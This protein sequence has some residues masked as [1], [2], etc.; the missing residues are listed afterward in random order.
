[1]IIVERDGQWFCVHQPDHARLG[2]QLAAHWIKPAAMYDGVWRRFVE[3]VGAHDDGWL[4]AE[5]QPALDAHGQPFDFITLPTHQHIEIWRRSIDL[6]AQRDI[7]QALLVA[8][9]ARW[10]YT[11]YSNHPGPSE[12]AA[13]A[14]FIGELTQRIVEYLQLLRRGSREDRD[15]VEPARMATAAA[16]L[17]FFDSLS[18]LL[19]GALPAGQRMRS[20]VFDG[21]QAT[22]DTRWADGN[23]ALL[24]C[25]PWPFTTD[26]VHVRC[27]VRAIPRR[28]C[29]DGAELA[30][31]LAA[32]EPQDKTWQIRP[33]P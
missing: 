16:L 23:Q 9:H 5:A 30:L 18:L 7:Y 33:L 29:K 2:G 25:D 14:G 8:H 31:R 3:I 13:A 21:H 26:S 27:P 19:I 22:I 20:V 11:H 1:M 4:Q 17:S 10:L 32:A 15:A 28:P 24:H 6:A 12:Q